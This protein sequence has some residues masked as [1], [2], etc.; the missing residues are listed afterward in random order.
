MCKK[1]RKKKN[2][3]GKDRSL[4]TN[5]TAP[6][7]RMVEGKKKEGRKKPKRGGNEA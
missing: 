7:R 1:K 6:R 4:P 5:L 2:I 3:H